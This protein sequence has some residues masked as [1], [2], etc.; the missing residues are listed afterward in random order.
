MMSN[1]SAKGFL[2]LKEIRKAR[3]TST[4]PSVFEDEEPVTPTVESPIIYSPVV[5]EGEMIKH[6]HS[7]DYR[8]VSF[9]FLF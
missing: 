1:L 5:A 6:C 3:G 9:L 4:P 2:T 8:Q 7:P